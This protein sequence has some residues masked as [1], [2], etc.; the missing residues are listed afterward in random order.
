M[1]T[2]PKR[3]VLR[4]NY[5]GFAPQGRRVALTSVLRKVSQCKWAFAVARALLLFA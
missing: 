5:N 2:K 3:I 1:P 4:D